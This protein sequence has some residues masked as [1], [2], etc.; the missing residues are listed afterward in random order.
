MS[1]G[2][3]GARPQ[4]NEPQM[5]RAVTDARLEERLSVPVK[6]FRPILLDRPGSGQKSN[7]GSDSPRVKTPPSPHPW[8]LSA[9][10]KEAWGVALPGKRPPSGGAGWSHSKRGVMQSVGR[11]VPAPSPLRP[12]SSI[13]WNANAFVVGLQEES[14]FVFS[15][16]MS[17][18][19][20]QLSEIPSHCGLRAASSI[21]YTDFGREEE[22]DEPPSYAQAM[23]VRHLPR[24]ASGR[25][26]STSRHVGLGSL[27][28]R[29]QYSCDGR[30]SLKTP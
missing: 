20:S 11:V 14:S 16:R 23:A 18:N 30:S 21:M 13:Q 9:V 1:W 26:Q 17:R 5:E 29:M 7:L 4:S 15:D 22:L 3:G 24:A 27:H 10:T 19:A 6:V 8:P 28:E 12:E 2:G 25:P